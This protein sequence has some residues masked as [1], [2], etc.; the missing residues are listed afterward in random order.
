M[1][2]SKSTHCHH[3]RRKPLPC[4]LDQRSWICRVRSLSVCGPSGSLGVGEERRVRRPRPQRKIH[5]PP[6]R[7]RIQ[8][9]GSDPQGEYRERGPL[10]TGDDVES[11]T[12][13]VWPIDVTVG[14]IG[15]TCSSCIRPASHG[16]WR[17]TRDESDMKDILSLRRR[18]FRSKESSS[19]HP[20]PPPR[21]QTRIRPRST[22]PRG[23]P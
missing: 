17:V 19:M 6:A 7:L 9:L 12:Q 20:P 23:P 16:S 18:S 2:A 8:S 11:H 13:N 15:T 21:Q 1:P 3:T 10:Y 5:S 4:P 22:A 14:R